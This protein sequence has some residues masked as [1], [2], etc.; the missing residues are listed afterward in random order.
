[1]DKLTFVVSLITPESD[2]QREQADAAQ[3]AALRLSVEL[4]I[5]YADNDAIHQSQQLL[6]VIQG[7]SRDVNALILEPA[8]ATAF[9]EVAR[10]AIAAGFGWVLMNREDASIAELTSPGK[11]PIFAVTSDQEETGR[12]LGRQ[13]GALLPGGGTVLC[14]QGPSSN[15]VSEQRLTG[16][17]QSRPENIKLR[18]LRSAHWTEAGGFQA[19]SSWLRLSTSHDTDIAGIVAQSDLIALGAHRAF[20]EQT[21]GSARDRWLKLPFLGVNGLQAGQAAVR[22]GLLASTV[23]LP[24]STVPAIEMLVHVYRD[25][26][27][28]PE[29]IVVPPRSFPEL[30]ML[31][32]R[33]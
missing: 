5:L 3:Q 16:M 27:R 33:R 9:P 28:P 31:V 32:P 4:Q 11:P 22:S 15:P 30:G 18:F 26:V 23:V 8:G 14:L 25:G 12:I 6:E 24:P 20:K 2:Y 19:I 17:N 13:L 10:A 29:R 21:A 7:P 1:M